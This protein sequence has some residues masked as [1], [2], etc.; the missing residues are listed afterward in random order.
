MGMPAR[1]VGNLGNFGVVRRSGKWH[2]LLA[3]GSAGCPEA[4]EKRGPVIAPKARKS[5]DGKSASPRAE[6][7]LHLHLESNPEALCLVRATLQRAAEV[8]HF[9]GSESRAIVRS[10]DEAL[11]NIIRH[12]Y[13]GRKGLPIEVSCWRLWADKDAKTPSGIEIVLADS[14]VAADPEKMKGRSLQEIRPGGLGLHFIKQSM[15]VVEFSR[16]NGKN[17]LRL[18]KY[19]APSKP[20]TMLEG[21]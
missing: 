18:V 12:A 21:E 14:G 8:V 2:C 17:L 1:P 13:Q 4:R 5:Q 15:D 19:L 6:L 20:E 3:E 9:K 7:L 16:K 11:A 10:V